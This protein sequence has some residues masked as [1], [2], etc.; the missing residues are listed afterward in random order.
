MIQQMLAIWSLVPLPFLEQLE[1]RKFSV[2]VL[3]KSDLEKFEHY[4]ARMWDECNYAVIWTLFGIAFLWNWNDNWPCPVLW[5][6]LSFPNLLAYWVQHFKASSFRTWNSSV[7][8]PALLVVVLSKAHLT[9][10]SRMSGSRSVIT[11]SWLGH[12]DHFCIIL[13]CILATSALYLLLLLGPYHFYPLLCPF[14]CMKCIY[15]FN[16]F[17]RSILVLY[18]YVL[19]LIDLLSF[20]AL[21]IKVLNQAL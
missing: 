6:L 21:Y 15:L 12:E 19:M 11:P 13:L 2:H 17:D 1:H 20:A 18:F 14:L 10:H 9:S 4:F 16:F 7:G 5:P 3:L 8:I